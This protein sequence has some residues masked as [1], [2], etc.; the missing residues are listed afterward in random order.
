[1]TGVS[2]LAGAGLT[3]ATLLPTPVPTSAQPAR[4]EHYTW[5]GAGGESHPLTRGGE[6]RLPRVC[7]YVSY[8]LTSLL[9]LS[10]RGDTALRYQ[11]MEYLFNEGPYPT[12][13]MW[14][15]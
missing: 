3:R 10:K 5:G 11:H 6:R 2:V 1:M 13:D 9:K 7:F 4:V 14:S 12:K 15:F 8:A